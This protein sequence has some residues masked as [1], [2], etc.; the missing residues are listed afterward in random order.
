MFP[1]VFQRRHGHVDPKSRSEVFNPHKEEA[2]SGFWIDPARP[3]Q[4]LEEISKD[5]HQN[6]PERVFH[7][8]PLAPGVGAVGMISARKNNDSSILATRNDLSTL[9]GLVASRAFIFRVPR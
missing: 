2:T 4:G 8:G 3:A 5:H 1:I 7:S 9:S 6:P